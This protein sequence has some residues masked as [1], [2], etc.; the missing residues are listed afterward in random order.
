MDLRRD[1]TLFPARLGAKA[2]KSGMKELF[3]EPKVKK[4]G[5]L[6]KVGCWIISACSIHMNAANRAVQGSLH[7]WC[8]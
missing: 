3:A 6:S 4:D 8:Y 2:G 7:E 1:A 5:T